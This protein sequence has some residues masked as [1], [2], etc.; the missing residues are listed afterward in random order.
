MKI[1]KEAEKIIERLKEHPWAADRGDAPLCCVSTMGKNL[2]FDIDRKSNKADIIAV[3]NTDDIDSDDEVVI[4]S[5]LDPSYFRKNGKIFSDHIYST[6]TTIGWLRWLKE[7]PSP[8]DHRQWR[9]RIGIHST[10]LGRDIMTIAQESG[11]FGFSIGFWPDDF[12]QPSKDEIALYSQGSKTPSSIVRHGNWFETSATPFPCNVNCQGVLTISSEA[13]D[14]SKTILDD[15][16]RKGM[17]RRSTAAMYGLTTGKRKFF[18]IAHDDG[19]MISGIRS[20]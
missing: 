5:G 6:Q 8:E 12:G 1:T 9:A 17:I 14:S 20:E 2:S 4:P 3:F 19:T 18:R 13:V 15:L 11:Q 10:D 7:Y 16:L